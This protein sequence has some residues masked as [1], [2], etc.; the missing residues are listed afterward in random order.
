MHSDSHQCLNVASYPVS[1][2]GRVGGLRRDL[3]SRG[4]EHR[5][6]RQMNNDLWVNLCKPKARP[7]VLWPNDLACHIHK[8]VH[9]VTG[10]KN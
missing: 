5:R 6:G 3:D 4:F 8:L 9:R 1:F 2:M 10:R 7:C